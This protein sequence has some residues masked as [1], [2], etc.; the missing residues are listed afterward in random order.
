MRKFIV[1][2]TV[3]L[4]T[5]AYSFAQEFKTS[6]GSSNGNTIT[7]NIFD[8]DLI[9]QGHD[10]K[11]VIITAKGYKAPP[12]R[13]EGLKPLYNT[14]SD[15]T[16]IGLSVKAEGSSITVDRASR[17]DI[18]YTIKV[19]KGTNVIINEMNYYGDGFTVK[20]ISGEIE[21]NSKSSDIKLV[22]VTGPVVASSTNGN[23]EAVFSKLNQNKPISIKCING[24]IDITLP[25]NTK[26][27][28]E[29]KS[30]NGEVYTNF[31][32]EQAADANDPQYNTAAKKIDAKIN[33]GGILL[34]LY[35]TNDDIYLR[36]K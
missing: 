11:D 4:L 25:G 34:S 3:A 18:D 20:D 7:I 8:C 29:M 6:F 21:I 9:V 13:A 31:E 1:F 19:P 16:N 2:L 12:K 24:Y 30:M 26:A 17:E 35:A 28:L 32:V 22:N 33:G 15:N 5:S 27:N 14:F 23:F 36:K 10:S